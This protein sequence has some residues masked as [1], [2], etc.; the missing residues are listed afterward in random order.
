MGIGVQGLA[1]VYNKMRLSFDDPES[2]EINRKIFATIYYFAMKESVELAKK[3]GV[4]KSYQGS[5]VSKG[6]FQFD[7]WN[8]N[9]FQNR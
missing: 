4:Y 9:Q 6:Q 2:F 1:D 5:P 7:L 8:Q 3:E